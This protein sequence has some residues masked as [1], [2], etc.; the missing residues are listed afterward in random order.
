[1]DS[2]V[3]V[4]QL[5]RDSFSSLVNNSDLTR[6]QIIHLMRQRAMEQQLSE[7]MPILSRAQ[8]DVVMSA[9]QSNQYQADDIVL[10][11]GELATRFF[12]IMNGM[13]EIQSGQGDPVDSPAKVLSGG[14]T[15]GEMDMLRGGAYTFTARASQPTTTMAINNNTIMELAK[16]YQIERG[17]IVQ[18][19][20]RRYL[21]SQLDDVMPHLQRRKR[22]ID[23]NLDFDD[24]SD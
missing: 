23:V 12:I 24:D 16:K 19:L 22:Q 20:T 10:T 8:I 4:M 5:D 14:Q 1:M 11:A 17:E 2:E 9:V 6:D 3:V 18:M 13:V 21:Q 7:A 15:F